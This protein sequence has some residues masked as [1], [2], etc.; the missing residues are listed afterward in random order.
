MN[1]INEILDAED[2]ELQRLIC[3]IKAKNG[4]PPENDIDRNIDWKKLFL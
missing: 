4:L 3:E 1:K 2:F